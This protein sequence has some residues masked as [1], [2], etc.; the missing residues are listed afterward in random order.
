MELDSS[1]LSSGK[2]VYK[3]DEGP[4]VK[5]VSV[6]L[7]GNKGL[8]SGELKKVL[9]T[10][11]R[12][13]LVLQGYYNEDNIEQ[14]ILKL[15]EAYQSKSY[16]DANITA[17]KEF[18]ADKSKVRITYEIAEGPAYSIE[19]IRLEGIK[20]MPEQQVRAALKSQAG[21]LYN[22]ANGRYGRQTRAQ[23]LP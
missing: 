21:Q 1:G 19:K 4:R 10:K 6:K 20:E 13:W 14:D 2:V 7:K 9:K 18:N 22:T 23:I 3:I 15:Q 17:K 12:K 11:T 16:L 8:T 5:V